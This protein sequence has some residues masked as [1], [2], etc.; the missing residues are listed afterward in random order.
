MISGGG[1]IIIVL[2]FKLIYKLEICS[3]DGDCMYNNVVMFEIIFNDLDNFVFWVVVALF[4]CLFD[5]KVMLL[6]VIYFNVMVF[7][8]EIKIF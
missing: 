5:V 3:G 1:D 2:C 6:S 8:F 4:S 7:K